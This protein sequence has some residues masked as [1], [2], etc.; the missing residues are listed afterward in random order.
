MAILGS[1][2]RVT[3]YLAATAPKPAATPTD[4]SEH[5]LLVDARR[6][7]GDDIDPTDSRWR[8]AMA[9][10]PR[11]VKRALNAADTPATFL[12]NFNRKGVTAH[13]V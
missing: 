10:D 6:K 4:R 11:L 5:P 3:R 8:V 1:A 2:T 7:W 9:G 13:A 12:A